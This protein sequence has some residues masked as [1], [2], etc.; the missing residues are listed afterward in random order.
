MRLVPQESQCQRIMGPAASVLPKFR[1]PFL[2]LRYK[3][4]RMWNFID[5][6]PDHQKRPHN[7][8]NNDGGHPVPVRV[9]SSTSGPRV[10][11][12]YEFA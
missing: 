6:P 1:W 10:T 11:D 5:A 12:Q 9:N 8:S 2:G 3:C 7:D 4:G